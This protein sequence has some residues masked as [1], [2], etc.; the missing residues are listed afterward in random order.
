MLKLHSC[1]PRDLPVTPSNHWSPEKIVSSV[2][3]GKKSLVKTENRNWSQRGTQ[4]C[5]E[6]HLTVA[7]VISRLLHS[8][9]VCMEETIL[10]TNTC[11][12]LP[13][14]RETMRSATQTEKRPF[15][16]T[17]H[18]ETCCLSQYGKSFFFFYFALHFYPVLA[19]WVNFNSSREEHLPFK[20]RVTIAVCY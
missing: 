4:C 19:Q 12:P 11:K 20:L 16:E 5:T 13:S 8:T 14:V 1:S 10:S 3:I 17:A 6:N 2:T 18:F 7:L 9:V 15:V